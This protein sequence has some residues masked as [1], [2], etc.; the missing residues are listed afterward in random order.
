MIDYIKGLVQGGFE[1]E[2]K[3]DLASLIWTIDARERAI[4]TS[5]EINSALKEIKHFSIVRNDGDISI[6]QKKSLGK[7][8]I[9]DKDIEVAMKGYEELI[10]K[11]KGGS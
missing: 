1:H 6:V 8:E 5:V 9:T 4:P 10:S 3:V 11:I 2:G 7:D